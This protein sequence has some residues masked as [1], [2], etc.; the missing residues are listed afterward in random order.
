MPSGRPASIRTRQLQRRIS[1][2]DA[3]ILA[4]AGN[5]DISAGFKYLLTLYGELYAAGVIPSPA[6]EI[7]NILERLGLMANN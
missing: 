6:C 4:H 7:S 1:D 5:G 3:A 2:A